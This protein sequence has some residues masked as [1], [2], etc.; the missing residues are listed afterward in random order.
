MSDLAV[1]AARFGEALRA[2]GVAVGADR[3]ARFT[4]AVLL[5][6]PRT[7]DELYRCALATLVSTPDQIVVLDRV[8]AA[9]FGGGDPADFRG[10]RPDET[11]AAGETRQV[12][13]SIGESGRKIE[14][15]TFG[16]AAEHLA[17]RDFADLEPGELA[18]LRELM[19]RFRIAT[20]SRRSR[21]KRVAPGGRRV[22]L[23]E[24][25][26]RAR[27]SGGEPVRLRRWVPREKPRKLVVLCDISGSM[28]AHAR[29]MLQ[30]LVCARLGARAEVFTFAT[31]LT[32]LTK[33]LTA[34]PAR[35]MREAGEQAPDWSGGTRIGV[36]LKEFIESYG[37]RGMARGAVVVIISDG[38]ETGGTELLAGQ[39]A[40]LSRLAFRV[41]WVNPRTAQPAYRPLVGGMAAVWPYCDFVVSAHRLD[42]LDE[43][44]DAVGWARSHRHPSILG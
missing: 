28:E 37:A 8:F 41:V 25:L 27:R 34:D 43:L 5:V 18:L 32:R 15:P 10:D 2:Q 13:E 31:R 23:R 33:V 11:L 17:T 35:A 3:S 44:L 16:S 40:R 4:Q 42:A 26:R 38:W 21:R 9:V 6:R 22:D 19:R 24:T 12:T 36:A 29:A 14:L 39:M 7:N 20:P 30:L 1:L